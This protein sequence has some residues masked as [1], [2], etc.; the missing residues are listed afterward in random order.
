[1]AQLVFLTGKRKGQRLTLSEGKVFTVGRSSTNDL[2]LR[3]HKVSRIH[4]QLEMTDAVCTLSD[5]NS[6]NGTYVNGEKVKE[7][8]LKPGDH[9][10]IGL[11]SLLYE[12]APGAAPARP[13]TGIL[14]CTQCG[15]SVVSKHLHNGSATWVGEK[16]LCQDCLPKFV[17]KQVRRTKSKE[18]SRHVPIANYI[19]KTVAGNKISEKIADGNL[20]T[21]FRAEHVTLHR[22]VAIK[23]L[24]PEVTNDKAWMRSY[25]RKA[26]EAG[27]LVH[28]N[29]VLLYD[30]G[31]ADG[32]YY[33]AMEYVPG[34]TVRGMVK[35]MKRVPPGKAVDLATQIAQAIEYA[36]EQKVVHKDIK[37]KNILVDK[38]GVAK[39]LGFGSSA[40]VLRAPTKVL[41]KSHPNVRDFRFC[42]PE[43]L[44]PREPLD[45]RSDIYS[46]GATLYYMLTGTA[47]FVAETNRELAQK[48]QEEQ[49]RP[50][51]GLADDVP[52]ILARTVGK[53]IEKA[54]EHRHQTPQELLH[55]LKQIG[56]ELRRA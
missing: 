2:A 8:A 12:G 39:L 31:E 41:A 24:A 54:P 23:I 7:K 36:Q 52:E 33:I 44:R 51:R 20:G 13:K 15:G 5:L 55:E 32:V 45:F 21:V 14:F 42:A 50:I 27:R 16:L 6:T 17:E 43:F 22:P 26:H 56:Q 28:P 1:M 18:E 46:L 47:P 49:P 37:P 38:L 53:M 29:I 19:G 9:V 4:C 3:D 35:R 30:I 10:A 34:E 11:T 48:V 25:L 40:F